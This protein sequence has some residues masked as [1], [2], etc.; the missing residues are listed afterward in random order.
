MKKIYIAIV[1]LTAAALPSMAQD[2]YEGAKLMTNDLNGTARYIGMGGAMEA[3]GADISVMGTN[4]AGIGLFRHSTVSA[5]MGVVSQQDATKF[6]GLGKTNFSFDQAGFVYSAQIGRQ[7]FVNIGINYHKSRNFDQ[8]LSATNNLRGASLN[9]V[10]F[11]KS[12]QGSEDRGGYDVDF[13]GD[14]D[15]MGYANP[16]ADYRAYTF[17]QVDYLYMNAFNL[18]FDNDGNASIYFNDGLDAPN[19]YQFDRAHRGWISDFDFNISGNINDRVYLG[20]TFGV[21]DVNYKA[22]SEYGEQMAYFDPTVSGNT[23]LG[24]ERTIDGAGFDVKAGIIFRPIE[25]SPFRI[26]LSVSTPTFYDLKT[27]NFTQFRYDW[28]EMVGQEIIY[29]HSTGKTGETYE[30]K[31]YTP[32]KFGVSLG[33]TI[34]TMVAL[35]ASYE[36]AD[37]SATDIRVN[38]VYNYDYDYWESYS[39]KKMNAHTDHTLKGV[40]T[41]KLGAELKPDPAMAVRVGYN[42]VSAMYEEDGVRD[43]TLNSI[44]VMYSS[45]TDYVNWG[46]TH[47]I[48]CGLGFKS[49][50]WNFDLAY[51]YS[52]TK[53][54]FHPFQPGLDFKFDDEIITNTPQATDVSNNRHQVMMTVGYTF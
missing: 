18:D 49:N 47:R 25:F 41:L 35:G 48:T 45:T 21:H 51:Q 28:Q 8:I 36:Y 6:D 54:T 33:H 23:L 3:L 4:P 26:G 37:Y 16:S 22:Y 38:D 17:S 2:T 1:A 12:E 11:Y 20:L 52:T 40:H 24:D 27:S 29:N 44:G 34:G 43:A 7:S 42:Y 10:G 9:K 53:G 39:D 46:D 13:N 19:S 14:G 32:W 15:L 31:M 30:F 5:S 50:A